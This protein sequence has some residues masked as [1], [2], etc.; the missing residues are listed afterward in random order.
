MSYIL[1]MRISLFLTV[2]LSACIGSTAFAQ[3]QRTSVPIGDAVGK[4]LDKGTLTAKG[5][6]PF[7]IRVSVSEPQNLS[8]PYQGTIEEWWV[9]ADQWRREVTD[10][11]GMHQ[12]VVEAAGHVTEKDDGDY[13]PLWLG[14]FVTALFDPIPNA[15][16][17]ASAGI[18]ID[19]ITM[20]N[21]AKSDAC[22][23]AK[24]QIGSGSSATDAFSNVCFDGEGRLKFFG[25]P[26]YNMEFSDYRSFSKK[27]IPH[28]FVEHPEPG[29]ELVGAVSFLEEIKTP[30]SA[31]FAP[32]PTED[33]R[34]RS[35]A[36]STAQLEQLT[37]GDGPIQWPN[38]RSGNTRG[39]LAIY[40][41]I[42]SKGRVR[43]AWPLNSDNAGLEDPAREQVR[44]WT[45]KPVTDSS[46]KPVQVDGG[47][48][49]YFETAVAD[50]IPVLT[51]QEARA[52]AINI[53]EPILPANTLPKGTRYRLHIS[54]NEEGKVAGLSTGDVDVPG[55]VKAPGAAMLA[56]SDVTR[57]WRFTPLIRDGKPRYFFADLIFMAD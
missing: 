3:I 46:G 42:D 18:T 28:K 31:M 14:S 23:K 38:V 33:S 35:V 11:D 6:R 1:C 50:P 25:S 48:G 51:D 21:G 2:A 39:H 56:A 54:V 8:S 34:F 27:Q 20:P 7:H 30:D 4:A 15:S 26:R 36:A 17:W 29:T 32:L 37:A 44:N 9:S 45:T 41:G 19:Q 52:L 53:A 16:R 43:E 49:F 10:K 40:I 12:T 55:T 24:S 5:I 22:A 57:Q 47:L 13:F